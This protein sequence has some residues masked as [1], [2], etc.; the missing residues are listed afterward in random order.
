MSL[1]T[2]NQAANDEE[3]LAR[4]EAGVHKETIANPAFGD[5]MF[6]GQVTSGMAPIK[7][8]FA[9]PVAVDNETAYEYAVNAD[10]PSPGGDPTVITDA[11]IGSAIQAHW[12]WSQGEGP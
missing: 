4:I 5:S 11:A 8:V 3:L 1:S 2:I 10:N 7:Q 9:Y 6:G 12:P